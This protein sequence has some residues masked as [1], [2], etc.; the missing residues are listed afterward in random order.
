MKNYCRVQESNDQIIHE[1][2]ISKWV[3]S[4]CELAIL[5]I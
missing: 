4:V 3:S 1:E 5:L 2:P